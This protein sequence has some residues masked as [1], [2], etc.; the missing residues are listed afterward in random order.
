MSLK[1]EFAELLKAGLD[2]TKEIGGHKF[3]IQRLEADIKRYNRLKENAE[4][5]HLRSV[6]L[7][8]HEIERFEAAIAENRRKIAALAEA[9]LQCPECGSTFKTKSGWQKHVN[10]C[11]VE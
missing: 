1:N 2:P 4:K 3:A 10:S 5:E 9:A 6:S 7:L 11:K 8:D